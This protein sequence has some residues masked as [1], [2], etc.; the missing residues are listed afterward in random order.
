MRLSAFLL[1]C[2][3]PASAQLTLESALRNLSQGALRHAAAAKAPKRRVFPLTL[4]P[5][6][7]AQD[8]LLLDEPLSGLR[9]RALSAATVELAGRSWSVGVVTDADYDEFYAVLRSGGDTIVSPLAP[10]GRF[11]DDTGVLISDDEGPVL[12]LNARISLLHP[13]N[14]TSIVAVDAEDG[15]KDSFTV[16]QLVEQLKARGHVVTVGR[17]TYHLF[18]LPEAD[19][20]RLSAERSLYLVRIAG[21]RTRGFAVRET[22]L[23]PGIPYRV[24]MGPDSLTLL[25]TADERLVIRSAP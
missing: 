12:R 13:I 25:K 9:D 6:A 7:P 8:P 19:G 15:S 24:T 17:A 21:T 10:L 3:F 16:G 1:L 4:T 5:A 23:R 18:V 22:A 14:G 2:A 20:D 11:L